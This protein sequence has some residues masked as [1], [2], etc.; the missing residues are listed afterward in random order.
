MVYFPIAHY[1]WTN[2]G[3]NIVFIRL[4]PH[5]STWTRETKENALIGPCGQMSKTPVFTRLFPSFVH[6]TVYS[7]MQWTNEQA[8]K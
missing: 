4:Y 6:F 2:E 5:L 3:K 1:R 7:K 8:Q